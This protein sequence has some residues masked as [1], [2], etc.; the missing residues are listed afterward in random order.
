[1][2]GKGLRKRLLKKVQGLQCT[3]ILLNALSYVMR[4]RGFFVVHLL[5]H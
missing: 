5:F 1:M 4:V 2:E 3:Y